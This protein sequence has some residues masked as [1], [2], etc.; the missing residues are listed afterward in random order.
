MVLLGLF[1]FTSRY[2]QLL[3][4]A[5]HVGDAL[6]SM[7]FSSQLVKVEAGSPVW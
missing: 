1:W 7:A 4:K 2:P 6:P 3:D 5:K